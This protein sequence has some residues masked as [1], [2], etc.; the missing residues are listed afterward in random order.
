MDTI[1]ICLVGVGSIGRRHLKLLLERGDVAVSVVEPSDESWARVQGEY[2][3][4]PRFRSLEEALNDR[5]PDAVASATPHGM[6]ADMAIQALDAGFHDLPQVFLMFFI[7]R[8][9]QRVRAERVRIDDVAPRTEIALRDGDDILR[10]CE[11]PRLGKFSRFQAS[12]LEQGSRTAV[13]EDALCAEAGKELLLLRDGRPV[14]AVH[15]VF[16][17]DRSR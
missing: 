13:P 8:I 9:F 15:A 2:P 4:V 14:S 11:V 5:R 16:H 7:A 6:H 1:R 10:M 17:I 3:D 12:R